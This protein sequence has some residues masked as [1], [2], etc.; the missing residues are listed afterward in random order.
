[1]GR[2][3]GPGLFLTAALFDV[4]NHPKNLIPGCGGTVGASIRFL[5]SLRHMGVGLVETKF[6][7]GGYTSLQ[8]D[9]SVTLVIELGFIFSI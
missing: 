1:M 8:S 5:V 4:G 2:D 6:I 7:V 3:V 9:Y